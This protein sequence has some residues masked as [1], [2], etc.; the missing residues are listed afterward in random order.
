MEA[1]GTGAV[2]SQPP[3]YLATGPHSPPGPRFFPLGGGGKRLKSAS[4]VAVLAILFL[5]PVKNA[6]ALATEELLRLKQAG[7]SEEL[8][9]YIVEADYRDIDKVLRLKEAGFTDQALL[10]I[11]RS[12]TT[13]P[14]SGGVSAEEAGP[15]ASEKTVFETGG[16]IKILWYLLYQGKPVLQNHQSV[17]D[18]RILLVGDN[19]IR[20]EWNVKEE[21]GLL[22]VF[23]RRPFTSPF[24]WEIQPGDVLE[25]GKEGYPW[26]LQSTIG[27]K[28][29]PPTDGKHYWIVYFEPKD[30]A[31]TD[32]L[33]QRLSS[34]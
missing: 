6:L 29:H 26:A 5:F 13:K 2:L 21:L 23:R 22:E 16:R 33:K 30:P 31:I 15:T 18:A 4:A 9:V 1:S 24:A 28:G 12:E 25:P 3:E 10:A 19:V 34:K 11:V 20:F 17:E 27:H 14:A 32:R 7:I 8:I